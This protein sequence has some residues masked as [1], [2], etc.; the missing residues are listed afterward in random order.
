MQTGLTDAVQPVDGDSF[1]GASHHGVLLQNLVEVVDGEGE[2]SA[3]GVCANTRRSP[4]LSEQ[5]NLCVAE[6]RTLSTLILDSKE[7]NLCVTSPTSEKMDL[8][9]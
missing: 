7:T 1:E 4:P 9:Y 2:E 3:V 6:T 5:A 8:D